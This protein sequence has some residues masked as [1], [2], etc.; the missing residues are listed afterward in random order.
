MKTEEGYLSIIQVNPPQSLLSLQII[1]KIESFTLF[2][3]Q[4]RRG[5]NQISGSKI[6]Y[7]NY[8]VIAFSAKM[9]EIH[10]KTV[11]Y[12]QYRAKFGQFGKFLVKNYGRI[13]NVRI[14]SFLNEFETSFGNVSQVYQNLSFVLTTTP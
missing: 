3:E 5:D 4:A 8:T 6:N 14:R 2:L 9:A 7:K 13:S 10:L 1:I 11:E 12:S